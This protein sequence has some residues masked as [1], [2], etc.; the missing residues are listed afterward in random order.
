MEY[1]GYIQAVAKDLGLHIFVQ[2][3]RAVL[4]ILTYLNKDFYDGWKGSKAQTK[5]LDDIKHEGEQTFNYESEKLP[6][7]L[8]AELKIIDEALNWANDKTFT[9]KVINNGGAYDYTRLPL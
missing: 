3:G 6:I 4:P 9:V 5:K 2:I 7:R 8:A 1:L